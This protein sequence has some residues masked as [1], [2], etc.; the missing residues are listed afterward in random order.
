MLKK[1]DCGYSLEPS[2]WGGSNEYPQS[3]YWAEIWKISEFLFKNFQFLVVKF[4]IFLNRRVF[5][6]NYMKIFGM[7]RW[8][9][10]CFHLFWYF[11]GYK[12]KFFFI[13][14]CTIFS[15]T[16]P[17]AQLPWWDCVDA[18]AGWSGCWLLASSTKTRLLFVWY[19]SHE[20]HK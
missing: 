16:R 2:R 6:M 8:F 13:V 5:E 20:T 4:S 10:I 7:C 18:Q 3:M 19:C 11:F 17:I 12:F 14:L 9:R 1:I 15:Y